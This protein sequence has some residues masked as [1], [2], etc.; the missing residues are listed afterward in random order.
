MGEES[1]EWMDGWM[2]GWMDDDDDDDDPASNELTVMWRSF[3]STVSPRRAA[4]YSRSPVTR[5]VH[6]SLARS[7][8]TSEA[9]SRGMYTPHTRVVL[10]TMRHHVRERL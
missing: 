5:V 8:S 3:R 7:L 10:Y 2:D 4:L 1:N 9:L 6:V